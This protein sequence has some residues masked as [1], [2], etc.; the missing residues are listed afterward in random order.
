MELGA[1]GFRP[2]RDFPISLYRFSINNDTR[3]NEDKYFAMNCRFSHGKGYSNQK[4]LR[5]LSFFPFIPFSF[6]W[7]ILSLKKRKKIY[8]EK[9]EGGPSWTIRK[10][11]LLPR[12]T[13]SQF[14]CHKH[15][16]VWVLTE[17]P[18]L[19]LHR[20]GG[21]R[22]SMGLGTWGPRLEGHVLGFPEAFKDMRPGDRCNGHAWPLLS[23]LLCRH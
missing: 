5:S 15:V 23:L 3:H 10:S 8:P 17:L 19:L 12:F 11:L 7:H 13:I 20:G 9:G 18:S 14:C 16:P 22:G 4:A 6:S 21:R 2:P 1:S